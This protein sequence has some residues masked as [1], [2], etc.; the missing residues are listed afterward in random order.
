[1]SAPMRS[2]SLTTAGPAPDH[3]APRPQMMTGRFALPTRSAALAMSLGSGKMLRLGRMEDE[4][5]YGSSSSS[6]AICWTSIGALII[7][8]RDSSL[9]V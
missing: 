3:I 9:A 8:G 4:G 6:N 5:L 2:A 7:T 1:M